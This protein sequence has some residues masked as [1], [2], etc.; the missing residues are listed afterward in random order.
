[1]TQ[2]KVAGIV[3]RV[4]A[5]IG[6]KPWK[7]AFIVVLIVIGGVGWVLYEKRDTLLEAWLTPDLPELKTDAIPDALS[8]L[9][10][11]TN[12]DLVQIWA[13]DLSAN[14][15]WFLGARRHDGDR[16]VI[17]SPRRLPI[18][19]HTS[20]VRRLVDVL[21]GQPVCVDLEANGTPVA[22]RLAERGMKRGCAVP[23]PP[24]PES[25]VGVIYL[26]WL[27]QTDASNENVSVGA[28]REVAR[29][30]ATH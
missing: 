10:T 18:I 22:R 15:Q 3:D 4:L 25:F 6:D 29:K 26:A 23:I 28:A 27:Q 19:D 21:D 11:E 17:P 13:V 12:A 20:D 24:S 30:L 7:A 2:D 16:P 9:S 1:M 5:F 14:S 8:K